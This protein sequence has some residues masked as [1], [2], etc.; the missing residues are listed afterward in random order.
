MWK[1]TSGL[2][3]KATL[4]S[5]R[6]AETIDELWCIPTSSRFNLSSPYWSV[7]DDEPTV[8]FASPPI[9]VF[10]AA[11]LESMNE[12]SIVLS[13]K[14]RSSNPNENWPYPST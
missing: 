5:D 14:P 9:L 10:F 8:M 2:P 4:S 3:L 11:L 12:S 13:T 1:L 7:E 6:V